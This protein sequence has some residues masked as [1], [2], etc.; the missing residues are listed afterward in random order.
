M[1]VH[2]LTAHIFP[3]RNVRY[4]QRGCG[5]FSPIQHKMLYKGYILQHKFTTYS[6]KCYCWKT[7]DCLYKNFLSK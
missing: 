6:Y 1:S 7:L 5:Y 3:D 2:F 4:I